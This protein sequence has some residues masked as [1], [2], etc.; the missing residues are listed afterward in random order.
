MANGFT[1]SETFL[2][3]D[4]TSKTFFLLKSLEWLG[5]AKYH[6]KFDLFSGS[7][8]SINPSHNTETY[9]ETCQI[10]KMELLQK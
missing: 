6:T 3:I 8:T 10:S 1:E 4:F 9:S 7:E 2:L 5:F